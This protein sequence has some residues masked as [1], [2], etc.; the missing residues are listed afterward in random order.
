M[1]TRGLAA[2]SIRDTPHSILFIL[3]IKEM[4]VHATQR[5]G[6]T[7]RAEPFR[8]EVVTADIVRL[9]PHRVA[10][11]VAVIG[12][13]VAPHRA[14]LVLHLAP[15]VEADLEALVAVRHVEARLEHAR[16]SAVAVEA[17][18]EAL[19]DAG[20]IGIPARTSILVA[21]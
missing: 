10:E 3:C 2:Y 14:L 7:K 1:C 11:Q 18:L 12:R 15:Q 5:V 4:Q 17:D 21:L 13:E 20:A 16:V 9:A 19:A 8:S 6:R